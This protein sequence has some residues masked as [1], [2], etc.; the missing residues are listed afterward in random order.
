MHDVRVLLFQQ[1]LRSPSVVNQTLTEHTSLNTGDFQRDLFTF[2]LCM[3]VFR[4]HVY[5]WATCVPSACGGSERV[6]GLLEL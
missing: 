5:M 2:S 1:P 6:S 4:R 3:H